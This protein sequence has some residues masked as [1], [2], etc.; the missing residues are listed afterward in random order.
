MVVGANFGN[1]SASTPLPSPRVPK[2]VGELVDAVQSLQVYADEYFNMRTQALVSA[3]LLFLRYLLCDAFW[4]SAD[5]HI[6]VF[7]VNSVLGDYRE[8]IDQNSRDADIVCLRC[9]EEDSLLRKLKETIQTARVLRL[10]AN[11]AP[12]TPVSTPTQVHDTP[13]PQALA[14]SSTRIPT[15]IIELIPVLNGK[16]LCLR[17][18]SKDGCRSQKKNVCKSNRLAHF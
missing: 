11:A 1:L 6:L 3:M 7:W 13:V 9:S 17:Y 8:L 5:M 4:T 15:E 14:S 2:S 16:K 18:L 12:A 10:T